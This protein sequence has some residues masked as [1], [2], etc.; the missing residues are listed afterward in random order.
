METLPHCN[1]PRV[2]RTV[3]YLRMVAA[4]G[5]HH[6]QS[7]QWIHGLRCQL[8]GSENQLT[9]KLRGGTSADAG[10]ESS[11]RMR[12]CFYPRRTQDQRASQASTEDVRVDP[13]EEQSS[14][15]SMVMLSL[16]VHAEGCPCH[17]IEGP[18]RASL[19]SGYR[20]TMESPR[21]RV[22]L[23]QHASQWR[24]GCDLLLHHTGVGEDDQ[25]RCVVDSVR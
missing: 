23:I 13:A 20:W 17:A 8:R 14:G 16:W 1:G 19:E 10:G 12:P 4:V 25:E 6:R 24:Q 15:C 21:R 7:F 2:V 5:S 3:R 9:C 22:R 18:L 11:K